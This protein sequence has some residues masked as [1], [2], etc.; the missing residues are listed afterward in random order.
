[1]LDLSV[2]QPHLWDLDDPY[3]YRV[4]VTVTTTNAHQH[5]IRC[6]FRELRLIDGYFHLNGK[7]LFLKS[8]HTGN[9]MPIGQQAPVIPDFIRRDLLYAKAAGFNT[10]RFIAGVAYPDQ[11]DFCDEIGLMVWESSFA[12]W[13]L[14]DSPWM[15]ERFNRNTADMVRRDRNHPSLTIWELLNETTD[16]P[17]FRHAVEFLP[18][19]RRLD[20][21][22]LILLS[23]GRWDG[24]WTIGSASNPGSDAWEPVWGVEGSG[25]RLTEFVDPLQNAGYVEHAGDAHYYPHLPQTPTANATIRRLGHGTKPVLLS[26]YGIGSMMDVIRDGR[27]FEQVG[28]RPDLEDAGALRLQSELF[29]ADWQRLG[30]DDVYPFPDDLLR[31]SQRLHARQR[32]LGFN[33]IRSN[34]QLCG[35]NLTGMLDHALT[36]EGLWTFWREWKPTTF[37]AVADGWSP[38]RW[39]LFV[40]PSHAYTDRMITVEAVLATE[41]LPCSNEAAR[42]QAGDYSFMLPL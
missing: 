37:D 26:E 7:R 18:T 19:L 17:V 6:G 36:G 25:P 9:H 23:S 40:D 10:V 20:S 11:L 14:A 13:C 22:R 28:A 42:R 21:S 30:F 3:L 16:G 1:M 12:G 8:T 41:E 4:T 15:A 39:C 24:D 31:E 29:T 33:L 5:A 34:P 27:H 35:Y 32:T 2:A 38:L